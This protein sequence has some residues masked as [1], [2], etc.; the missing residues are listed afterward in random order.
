MTIPAPR[1]STVTGSIHSPGAREIACR[2][3]II[4]RS[5]TDTMFMFL[6]ESEVNLFFLFFL[7]ELIFRGST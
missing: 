2:T 3:R 4:P 1:V 5:R 7:D 6:L